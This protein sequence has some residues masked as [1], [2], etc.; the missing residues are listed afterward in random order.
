MSGAQGSLS[1][2]PQP[3]VDIAT[4]PSPHRHHQYP[5]FHFLLMLLQVPFF[6]PLQQERDSTVSPPS[7]CE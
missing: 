3:A 7:G 6:P 2:P 4:T 5:S 1:W